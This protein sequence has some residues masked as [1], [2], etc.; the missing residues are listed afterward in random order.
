LEC[1]ALEYTKTESSAK[2]ANETTDI[3][4]YIHSLPW[5]MKYFYMTERE[6][7]TAVNTFHSAYVEKVTIKIYNMGVSSEAVQSSATSFKTLSINHYLG[8][9]K[10]FERYGPVKLGKKTTP[11]FLNR[12]KI[13]YVTRSDTK[14]HFGSTEFGAMS[15][16]KR[17]D[18][19]ITYSKI[20]SSWEN[21]ANTNNEESNI[22]PPPLIEMATAIANATTS[23]GLVYKATYEPKDGH[24]HNRSSA[25]HNAAVVQHKPYEQNIDIAKNGAISDATYKITTNVKENDPAIKYENA[26]IDNMFS[27]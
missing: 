25:F 27:S 10:N 22:F 14:K 8:I 1:K 5:Q 12:S 26:T 17:V 15:E 7:N 13:A 3:T 18:N 19:R 16:L 21:S 4:A 9:W 20:T 2:L 24:F 23:A 6:Y 11:Q